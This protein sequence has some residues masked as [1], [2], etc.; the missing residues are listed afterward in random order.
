[1]NYSWFYNYMVYNIFN[2]IDLILYINIYII[3]LLVIFYILFNIRFKNI[4]M[5]LQYRIEKKGFILIVEKILI[6]VM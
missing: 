6:V 1:M 2:I 3:V 5:E 4:M